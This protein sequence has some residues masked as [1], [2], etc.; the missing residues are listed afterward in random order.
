LKNLYFFNNSDKIVPKSEPVLV[1]LL[2]VMKANPKLKIEIQGHICC[3]KSTDLDPFSTPRAKAVYDYLLQNKIA[4]N[5]MTY[6][7]F[8]VSRPVHPIPEKTAQ[9]EDDNRRVEI[10]IVEN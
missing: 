6:K 9:E 1:E 3:R 2:G 8:G 5:R 10:M 4:A 7:G